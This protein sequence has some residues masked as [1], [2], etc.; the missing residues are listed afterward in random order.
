MI[1]DWQFNHIGIATKSIEATEILYRRLSYTS[2]N[3]FVD[4]IQNVRILFLTHRKSP[5]IELIEPLNSSSPISKILKKNGVIPYHTCYEVPLLEDAIEV[6]SRNRFI[7][8]GSPVQAIA[9]NNRRIAFLYNENF[10]LIEL[11]EAIKFSGEI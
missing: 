5:M 8:I 1:I 11:L 3:I 7:K 9:F 4:N 2:S 10:G 6:L